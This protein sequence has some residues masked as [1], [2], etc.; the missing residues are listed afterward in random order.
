[1]PKESTKKFSYIDQVLA[2]LNKSVDLS[3]YSRPIELPALLA[4]PVVNFDSLEDPR[5]QT[6]NQPVHPNLKPRD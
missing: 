1:M 5:D 4:E 2:S 3:K 6:V